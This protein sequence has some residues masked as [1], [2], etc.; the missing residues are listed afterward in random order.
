MYLL[1]FRGGE[2]QPLYNKGGNYAHTVFL[3]HQL[4]SFLFSVRMQDHGF[5]KCEN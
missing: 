3:V 1:H 5:L 2:R 4:P